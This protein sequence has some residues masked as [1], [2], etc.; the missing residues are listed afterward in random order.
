MKGL[1]TRL[2]RVVIGLLLLV[3]VGINV[4]NVAAR[5]LFRAPLIWAEEVL[6][7]IMIWCIFIGIILVTVNQAHLRMDV[8][9]ASLPKRL[10][11]PIEG[12]VLAVTILV[13]AVIVIASSEAL[14]TLASYGQRS[15]VAEI[16]MV[17][18][19]LAIPIGFG[20]IVVVLLARLFNSGRKDQQGGTHD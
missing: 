7:F 14:F 20:A 8:F 6:V 3:A 17:I 9:A 16:P 11:K 4:A 2:P 1:F 18:P 13:S 15:I 19:H 5:H 10:A 12:V